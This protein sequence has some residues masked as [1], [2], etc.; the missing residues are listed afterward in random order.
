MCIVKLSTIFNGLES[1]IYI[2]NSDRVTILDA[3]QDLCIII[4]YLETASLHLK[5]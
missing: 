4:V 2:E 3:F 1:L 5:F